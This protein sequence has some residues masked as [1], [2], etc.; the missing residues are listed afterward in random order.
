[1]S[2]PSEKIATFLVLFVVGVFIIKSAGNAGLFEARSYK[3]KGYYVK[4]PEGWIKAKDFGWGY[5]D[6]ALR[7][8]AAMSHGQIISGQK[9][10]LAIESATAEEI[11]HAAN[12]LRHQ[13]MAMLTRISTEENFSLLKSER[14]GKRQLSTTTSGP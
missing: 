11:S 1:M 12:W 7:A 14:N 6:R 4:I 10:Y 13:A 2:Q 9:G 8:I 3:G 5:S